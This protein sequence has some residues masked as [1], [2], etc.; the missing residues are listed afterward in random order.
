MELQLTFLSFQHNI[1]VERKLIF[2][3]Q[4]AKSVKVG[5]KFLIYLL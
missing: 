1:L 5:N 4:A 2:K 3:I